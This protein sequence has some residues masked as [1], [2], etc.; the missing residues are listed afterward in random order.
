MLRVC[1]L[2]TGIL[3]GW[4]L[5]RSVYN[6]VLF[7]CYSCLLPLGVVPWAVAPSWVS[8]RLS[9][10]RAA[11]MNS[12]RFCPCA[13]VTLLKTAV[14]SPCALASPSGC[15]SFSLVFARYHLSSRVLIR[16]VSGSLP[17]S[18]SRYVFSTHCQRPVS[19]VRG[20]S[21]CVSLGHVYNLPFM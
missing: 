7:V 10:L 4:C 9:G 12:W 14:I 11:W 19:C 13:T 1:G 2:L 17:G 20:C 3:S 6:L 5:W 16:T 21:D 15:W 8:Q 18:T